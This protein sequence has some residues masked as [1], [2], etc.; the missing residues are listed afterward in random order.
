MNTR[1]LIS[2]IAAVSSCLIAS[3]QQ[4]SQQQDRS[5]P[6]LFRN[7]RTETRHEIVIPDVEGFKVVKTDL[8]VHTVY[9][10]GD[11]SP[12]FRVK[13]AWRDGLDALVISDHIEYRP[14]D[15][16]FAAYLKADKPESVDLNK[17][18]NLARPRAEALGITLIPATEITRSA[19]EVGHFNALFT[20]DNNLIPD[21][22]PLQAIRNAKKQGAI[23]QNNH[24]GWARHDAKLTSTTLSAIS[25]G[26]LDGME[27]YNDAEFYPINI[28]DA[29]NNNLYVCSGTDIHS[30]IAH[31]FGDYGQLRNMTFVLAK[32]SSAESIKEALLAK[33]TLA[34]GFGDICGR[35]ELLEKFFLASMEFKTVSTEK[36]GK[37]SILVTNK[38]SLPYYLITEDMVTGIKVDGMCSVLVSLPAGKDL[39]FTVQNMW[40]GLDK[41]PVIKIDNIQ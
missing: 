25:E 9:S 36:N 31:K 5:N 27:C 1:R 7:L 32:D 6:D 18:V 41:H 13:E 30:T 4:M 28:E 11:T 21:P 40:Y 20:T 17:S 3:A 37:R 26:L 35:Q 16:K 39:S 24:P 22:D 29:I 23:V 19:Q 33:R 2:C 12:E 38:S 10:D 34:Y 14:S 15:A 8:H